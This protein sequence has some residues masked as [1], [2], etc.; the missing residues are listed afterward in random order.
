MSDQKDR[1]LCGYDSIIEMTGQEI[2]YEN[3]SLV[4]RMNKNKYASGKN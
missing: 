2:R 4:N 1:R 3:Y